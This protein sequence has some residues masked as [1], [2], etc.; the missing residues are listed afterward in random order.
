M[1]GDR[2]DNRAAGLV[3]MRMDAQEVSSGE[4][5]ASS[6]TRHMAGW[7]PPPAAAGARG[8]VT[9]EGMSC[10]LPRELPVRLNRERQPQ[11]ARGSGPTRQTNAPWGPVTNCGVFSHET[12]PRLFFGGLF[13][14]AAKADRL[15]APALMSQQD[16]GRPGLDGLGRGARDPGRWTGHRGVGRASKRQGPAFPRHGNRR[17]HRVPRVFR[18]GETIPALGQLSCA[19]LPAGQEG[20]TDTLRGLRAGILGAGNTYLPKL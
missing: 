9:W 16:R 20:S 19:A 15:C 12:T 1:P 2:C 13:V 3:G 18:D 17:D 8:Q 7:G 5:R 14:T 10:P 11:V 4:H 6:P